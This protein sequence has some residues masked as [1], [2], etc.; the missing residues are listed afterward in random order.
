VHAHY[1]FLGGKDDAAFV[2][3]LE[4]GLEVQR[5]VRQTAL[6]LEKYRNNLENL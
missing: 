4:H 5:L 1:L 3:G 2:P 6:H